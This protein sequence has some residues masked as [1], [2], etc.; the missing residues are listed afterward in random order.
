MLCNVHACGTKTTDT[1]VSARLLDWILAVQYLHNSSQRLL[2][3][4]NV[5]YLFI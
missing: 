3:R 5:L 1:S 2:S 4:C